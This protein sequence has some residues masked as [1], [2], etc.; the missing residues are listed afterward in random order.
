MVR[1]E[2]VVFRK[3]LICK[4]SLHK[5]EAVARESGNDFYYNLIQGSYTNSLDASAGTHGGGGVTDD[6]LDGVTWTK[7]YSVNTLQRAK[8]LL[9]LIRWW[10]GNHHNHVIDPECPN[11]SPEAAAQV[12]EVGKGGDGL[13]GT[14]SDNG[15]R[16]NVAKIVALFNQRRSNPAR[17]RLI[18]RGLGVTP[19]DG[20]WG[21][22]TDAAISKVRASKTAGVKAVQTGLLVDADGAWGPVTEKAYLALRA[23][24][25]GK[26]TTTVTPTIDKTLP[27]GPFPYPNGPGSAYGPSTAGKNWWSGT[28]YSSKTM[29]LTSIRANIKRIQKA[30]KVTQDGVYGPVTTAAVKKWQSAHRLYVDGVTGPQTWNSM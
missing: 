20:I 22:V 6:E 17:V 28:K 8:M 30:V 16:T 13:V 23:A 29:S 4:H 1:C 15:N 12:L 19:I 11:L 3:R 18:Q 24:A 10:T 9:G 26:T 25:Y 7:A 27:Y 21:P 5:H 2:T 14:L